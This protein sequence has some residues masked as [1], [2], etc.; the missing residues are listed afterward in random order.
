MPGP[1]EHGYELEP[2]RVRTTDGARG[3]DPPRTP[4]RSAE[5]SAED[6][7]GRQDRLPP[8]HPSSRLSDDGTPKP[9]LVPLKNLEL[10]E[11]GDEREPN[12]TRRV[13]AAKDGHAES[14]TAES[15]TAEIGTAEIG[16]TEIGTA[17]VGTAEIGTAE[18]GAA[19][20]AAGSGTAEIGTA[21]SGAAGSGGWAGRP[22]EQEAA[23]P[24]SA[25]TKPSVW[26]PDVWASVRREPGTAEPISPEHASPE[27]DSSTPDSSTPSDPE[28]GVWQRV[29][30]WPEARKPGSQEQGASVWGAHPGDARTDDDRW[31]LQEHES[32]AQDLELTDDVSEGH[33]SDRHAEATDEKP[34]SQDHEPVT[35]DP[36]PAA[37]E[38]PEAKPAEPLSP[39]QV[40]IAVRAHGR[41]R[42]AEGRSVF[43]TYGEA[44]L[45]PAMRRIEEQLD[46]G[47]LVPDTEK[48]ALKSLVRQP[49]LAA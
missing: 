41:C 49:P 20:I 38:Q 45:T 18:G 36:A 15:D 28:P 21:E 5:G 34:A 26:E 1:E 47:E 35:D 4:G 40:R 8:G 10:P 11:P 9:P 14:D 24:E 25:G 39:E 16:T 12:G 6:L 2:S 7:R 30:Q 31:P 17:D 22:R 48:Y 44:G 29:D 32:P 13:L 33:Q 43:G 3:A 46:H 27:P 23:G 19:E 42:L 37:A